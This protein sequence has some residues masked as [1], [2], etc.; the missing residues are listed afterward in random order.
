MA[1]ILDPFLVPFR[2]D[3]DHNHADA[4]TEAIAVAD[5]ND[6]AI[7]V[8][9]GQENMDVLLDAL[10]HYGYNPLGWAAEAATAMDRIVDGARLYVTNESGIYLPL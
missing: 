8:L 7:A 4:H 10:E 2:D 9:E 5:L 3:P 6:M 1:D